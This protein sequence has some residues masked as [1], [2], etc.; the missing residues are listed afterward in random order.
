MT[1]TTT[2]ANKCGCGKRISKDATECK[3]CYAKKSAAR[4]ATAMAVVER[5]TCPHCHAPL[6]RNLALTGWWQCAGYADLAMRRPEYRDL[7]KCSFQTFTA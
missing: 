2:Q 5:G 1:N 3:A 4:I 6:I 7:P